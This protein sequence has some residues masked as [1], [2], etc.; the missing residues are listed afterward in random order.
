VSQAV[1]RLEEAVGERLI[2]RAQRDGSLT[3]AGTLL[4]DYAARMIQLSEEARA[5]LSELR[6]V[7][8]GRVQIGANEAA[9]HVLLPIIQTYL[10]RHPRVQIDIRRVPSR[11]L[12]QEL[13][14][15]A[16]DAGVMTFPPADRDLSS[17]TLASD[18]LVLL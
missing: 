7:G 9:V 18:S 16:I 15:R 4:L 12:P 8:R 13:R 14:R 1:R 3:Q 17:I 5:S 10:E 6:D 11:D 2:D